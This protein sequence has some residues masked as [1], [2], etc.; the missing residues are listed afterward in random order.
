[1]PSRGRKRSANDSNLS[2]RG[3]L[4]AVVGFATGAA[5]SGCTGPGRASRAGRGHSA[6]HGGNLIR[7]E[8]ELEGTQ[9]WLLTQARIDPA[10]QYRC[11][12]IEGYC[13][14]TSVCAGDTLSVFVNTN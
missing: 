3:W 1:M 11:P 4:K 9:D 13:A 8:N 14:R 6:N 2:R 10:S 5:V 7:E 12:W